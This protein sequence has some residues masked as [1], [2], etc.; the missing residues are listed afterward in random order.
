MPFD[1]G[2]AAAES[3]AAASDA[4]IRAG[5]RRAAAR[6]IGLHPDWTDAQVAAAIGVARRDADVIADARAALD[7]G[8][9]L[10]WA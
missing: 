1:A 8:E 6:L 9:Q 10:V 7:R 2:A 5:I 4:R 3:A